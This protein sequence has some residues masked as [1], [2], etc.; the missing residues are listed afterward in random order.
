MRE[1]QSISLTIFRTEPLAHSDRDERS[2]RSSCSRY[3]FRIG[4]TRKFLLAA[5][6][7]AINIKTATEPAH[8]LQIAEIT[9]SRPSETCRM[10]EKSPR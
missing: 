8:Q 10:K 5:K 1:C 6:K 3:C 7:P 4:G 2:R 9:W